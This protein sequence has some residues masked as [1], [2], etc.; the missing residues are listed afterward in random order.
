MDDDGNQWGGGNDDDNSSSVRGPA[1]NDNIRDDLP[2]EPV[3]RNNDPF[4]PA[5][6][7]EEKYR[8][9]RER[10]ENAKQAEEDDDA[11]RPFEDDQSSLDGRP[12]PLAVMLGGSLANSVIEGLADK[13]ESYRNG[14]A[15]YSN[16]GIDEGAR[17]SDD[18]NCMQDCVYYG[19][20]CCQCTI[21]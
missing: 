21:L 12:G 19:V 16:F 17:H 3:H 18:K 1:Y 20:L 10:M 15:L 6:D 5:E 11:I 4:S 2:F 7:P 13:Q 14:K 9:E 8:L